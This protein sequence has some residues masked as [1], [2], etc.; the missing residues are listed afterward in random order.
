MKTFILISIA[1]LFIGT[2]GFVPQQ[3]DDSSVMIIP[4]S[5]HMYFSDADQE[6]AKFNDK[7]VKEVRTLFRYGVNM[8]LNATI[9]N[10]HRTRQMLSDTASDANADL[11]KIYQTITYFE[12]KPLQP[13]IAGDASEEVEEEKPRLFKSRDRQ[14]Q[15]TTKVAK[16]E[17]ARRYMN[18]RINN[19][20]MLP[21]LREKYG[22]DLFLFINQFNLV[23]NY[24]HCLDRATNTFEREFV[25][26]YSIFDY[27][28]KQIAGDAVHITFPSNSN[29]IMN[30]M[31]TNFPPLAQLVARTLPNNVRVKETDGQGELKG[32]R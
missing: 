29:N 23:T 25:V 19:P 27:T 18:V 20:K 4:F 16:D 21:F 7:N 8:N 11:S 28:G 26:H 22:T 32:Q 3:G 1:T 12:D 30:L 24:E 31:K 14:A 9:L 15:Q 2:T 13:E 10:Q 5:P 17:T 6:L